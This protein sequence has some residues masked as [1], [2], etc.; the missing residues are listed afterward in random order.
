MEREREGRETG[1]DERYSSSPN[2]SLDGIINLRV[3]SRYQLSLN[4]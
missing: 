1:K 4:N 3:N 2:I